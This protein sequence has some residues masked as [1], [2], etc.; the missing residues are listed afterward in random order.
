MAVTTS[1]YQPST[2]T[3]KVG[4]PVRWEIDGQNVGGCTRDIVVPSLHIEKTLTKGQNLIAF[5]PT[6]TGTI[7]FSCGMG[8]VRG[9]INVI[10]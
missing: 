1:G 7:P 2:L 8:M 5:T 6:K 10:N 3:V 9:S 4:V